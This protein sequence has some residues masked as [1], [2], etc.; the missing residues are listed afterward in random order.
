MGGSASGGTGITVPDHDGRGVHGQ[1]E[2]Q[3]QEDAAG[4]DRLERAGSG[5]LA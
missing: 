5:S 1:Q 2:C 4:G 3:E